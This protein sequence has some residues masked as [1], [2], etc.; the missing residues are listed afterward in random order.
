MVKEASGCNWPDASCFQK[1]FVGLGQCFFYRCFLSALFCSV[2]PVL[3]V[4]PVLAVI[5]TKG[6]ILFKAR[7][8]SC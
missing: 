5:P 2:I 4:V 7:F 3:A 1:K 6:G 8:F